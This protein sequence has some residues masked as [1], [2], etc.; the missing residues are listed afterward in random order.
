MKI[1]DSWMKTKRQLSYHRI[2]DPEIEAESL[3]RHI[4]DIERADFFAT[5]NDELTP[6]QNK[7]IT[8]LAKRRVTGEPLAY[9]LEHRE[10]YGMDFYINQSVLV[11][12]QET[13]LL[14]DK[15]L[16]FSHKRSHDHAE[17]RSRQDLEIADI[18]TGSGAIAIAI[19]HHL[20]QA[21]IY[22]SDSSKSALQIADINRHNHYLSDRVHLRQGDLLKALRAPVDVIVSNPPYLTTSEIASCQTEVRWE[23]MAALHGGDDGLKIL[24]RL[25]HQAP[26]YI[27]PGGQ[28]LMEIAPQLLLA[29]L[30]I[31]RQTCPTASVSFTNDLTGA[32]RVVSISLPT[33]V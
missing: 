12:R 5:L 10:F 2:A 15:V 30:Q 27:R 3:L 7:A 8:S 1:R 25:L 21:T 4:L 32:P 29:V 28:L 26:S 14:V 13:E 20:P 31:G 11:P 9:I 16:E 23:P 17:D 33:H 18:G 19:A 6:S 22:A 24:R